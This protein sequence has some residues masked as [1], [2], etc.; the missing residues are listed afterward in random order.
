M[1]KFINYSN[2]YS[3]NKTSE[4]EKGLSAILGLDFKIN[5]KK[6]MVQKKRDYLYRWGKCLILMNYISDVV[7]E[8]AK[9]HGIKCLK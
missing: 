6:W 7:W 4:I 1:K 2:L 9:D 8:I 3:L 5:E